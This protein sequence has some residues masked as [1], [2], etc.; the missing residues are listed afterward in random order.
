MNS[1][2]VYYEQPYLK[3]LEA[4]VIAITDEGVLLDRTICYPEGGGQSG[5]KGFIGGC[6]LLDTIHGNGDEILHKV[7]SPTFAVGDTVLIELDWEHRYHYM[8]MHTAQHVA[9]GIMHS[10]FSIGTVSVHQGEKILTIETD[11]DEIPYLTCIAIED[12]VNQSVREGHPLRYE[13]E[14]QKDAQ[15]LPLRRS[16]KVASDTIRLVIVED[17]DVAACGGLHLANTSEVGLFQY[18]GQEKLRGH[19][20]LIF[21]VGD[22]ALARIRENRELV[23]QL[24][25]LHS[26]QK[27]TLLEVETL[28]LE[29]IGRDRNLLGK[30]AERI[31][32]LVLE[33]LVAQ[34][35]LVKDVPLVLWEVEEDIDMKQVASAFSH[36]EELALC[37]AKVENGKLLWLVGLA[38]KASTLLDFNASRKRLLDPISGKGGGK[39]SLFQGVGT[40]IPETLFSAFTKALHETT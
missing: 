22:E 21:T 3:S 6:T 31:A 26:A 35:T 19:I 27:E 18:E 24:C 36:V 12:L 28:L 2:P 13:V 5:D 37:A 9:S 25:T 10:R 29:Q 33:S 38:G 39:G 23:D 30:K 11:Q 32:L 17:V 16:I 8:Q 34:A 7:E 14:S 20:R 1:Q 40:G 4:T 15:K